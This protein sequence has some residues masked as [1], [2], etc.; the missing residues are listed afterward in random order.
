MS[1]LASRLPAW[2]F[3]LLVL[4][5]ALLSLLAPST[6]R[7]RFSEPVDMPPARDAARSPDSVYAHDANAA[8]GELSAIS[9]L[10]ASHEELNDTG[11]LS[12]VATPVPDP[13]YSQADSG[14][15]PT[16]ASPAAMPLVEDETSRS[17]EPVGTEPQAV[18]PSIPR[19]PTPQSPATD[20]P[21]TEAPT[22]AALANP[23]SSNPVGE[24]EPTRNEPIPS[25]PVSPEP[26]PGTPAPN[27]PAPGTPAP[28]TPAPGTPTVS[29]PAVSMPE[30]AAADLTLPELPQAAPTL[31]APMA[32]IG[33]L[34]TKPQA[35][36]QDQSELVPNVSEAKQEKLAEVIDETGTLAPTT[37]GLGGPTPSGPIPAT[38]VTALPSPT[39]LLEE[40]KAFAEQGILVDWSD[41]VRIRLE[42]LSGLSSLEDP[43]AP[44]LLQE[45]GELADQAGTLSLPL[46]ESP[47]RVRILRAAYGVSRRVAVWDALCSLATTDRSGN[48]WSLTT[49]R[50]LEAAQLAVEVHLARSQYRDLWRNYLCL[51]RAKELVGAM[52]EPTTRQRDIARV[53][54][55]R[56]DVDALNESQTQFLSHPVFHNYRAALRAYSRQDVGL[57][58]M[59]QL[60]ERYETTLAS[61]DARRVAHGFQTLR[62]SP[63][64][65]ETQAAQPI[66]DH[67]RNANVRVA[68]SAA[69]INRILPHEHTSLD[70]VDDVIHSARVQGTSRTSSRLK[71]FLVP[72]RLQWRL[73]L[74]ARGD[75]ESQTESRKG[76][77]TFYQDAMANFD[78]R[79]HVTVDKRGIR[80]D[81]AEARARSSSDLRGLET[82]FDDIPL[83]N[84][85]ARGIANRQYHEQSSV[86]AAEVEA[87]VANLASQRL[88]QEVQNRLSDAEGEFQTRWL[89]PLRNMGLDPTPV[90]F[91]TT[92]QRL[93]VRYRIAAIHQLAAHTPRPQ[94][95][96]NSW[97]SVQLH[98]SAINNTLDQLGIG[99]RKLTIQ[100][101]CDEL[102]KKFGRPSPP[103]PEDIPEDMTVTLAQRDGI[104]VR[105]DG[106]KL[107]LTL[108][109]AEL[110]Q[111]RHSKWK[112]FMVQTTYVPSPDQRNAN[113]VRDGI[114]EL[115]SEGKGVGNQ[116]ALR[117]IFSKVLSKNRTISLINHSMAQQ[118]EFADLMINQFV[119]SD[120]WIGIAMAPKPNTA[121]IP[122]RRSIH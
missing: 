37:P 96:T 68:I 58:D 103:M 16:A 97:M 52:D 117:T 46:G 14:E 39:V 72:S 6:W 86:A 118:P 70:P 107:R 5:I 32:V 59:V 84:R 95:P 101:L 112:N 30:P 66:N 40:L 76:P 71:V 36:T 113:L 50:Q 41:A 56:L 19:N 119:L 62:W 38:T 110:S 1:R 23:P 60:I 22:T 20:A 24:T 8:R 77:A 42:R 7:G 79:K 83:F 78:A 2:P 91:E 100:E 120:G 55:T 87:R 15:A 82:D 18:E 34:E 29:M 63:L 92:D 114:I 27:T 57:S 31:E 33:P 67:Y 51:D 17:S 64:D 88:D 48:D 108:R 45:L 106:G 3:V 116:F 89:M 93:I 115:S 9:E 11:P 90:D 105:C 102:S 85:L 47:E 94:A 10:A 69:L 25:E 80:T 81:R 43:N 12:F 26:V 54:L 35:T 53:V 28:G 49:T 61:L 98:E 75:V 99:G 122:Y 111:N 13:D 121:R 44:R 4:A 104:R 65:S 73:G 21:E 74:E 109:I